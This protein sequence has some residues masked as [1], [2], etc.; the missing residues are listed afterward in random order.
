ME[1]Y[2]LFLDDFHHPYDSFNIWKDS[3]YLKLKW[4]TARSHDEFV[5]IITTKFSDGE[6]PTLISWDHDLSDEHYEIGEKTGYKEFDYS[7][8]TIPTG[9]HSAQWLI[10][11]CKENNLDLPK[12]KV[13]SQST[14]GREN[15]N[16]ILNEFANLKK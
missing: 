7:L 10:Q 12:F 15:I 8:T 11:F 9:F 6:W 1:P 14:I 2:N 16:K 5:K 3:D 4:I 13:H